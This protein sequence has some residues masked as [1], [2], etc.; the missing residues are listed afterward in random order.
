MATLGHFKKKILCRIHTAVF[1]LFSFPFWGF[2]N[3]KRKE[4]LVGEYDDSK[5]WELL[6][7]N[8][9]RE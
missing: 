1:C 4:K 8:F 3:P 2:P 6:S 5:I 7:S 9:Q